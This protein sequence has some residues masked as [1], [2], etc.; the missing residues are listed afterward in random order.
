MGLTLNFLM[1]FMIEAGGGSCWKCWLKKIWKLQR[2]FSE[3][4]Y[5]QMASEKRTSFI[6][7]SVLVII[8]WQTS[9]KYCPLKPN[10]SN[11]STSISRAMGCIAKL[12]YMDCLQIMRKWIH[13]VFLSLS[14]IPSLIYAGEIWTEVKPNLISGVMNFLFF[15]DILMIW[16]LLFFE[17]YSLSAWRP[18]YPGWFIHEPERGYYEQGGLYTTHSPQYGCKDFIFQVLVIWSQVY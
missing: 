9:K 7:F 8:V 13:V 10:M 2:I 1:I 3:I 12:H 11:Y 16:F 14:E 6:H 4:H 17:E 5:L 15:K 18:F